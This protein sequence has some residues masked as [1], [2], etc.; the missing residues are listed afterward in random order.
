MR[1]IFITWV[2]ILGVFGVALADDKPTVVAVWEHRVIGR[3]AVP[4]KMTLYSNQKINDP[5]GK[6]VWSRSG[7]TLTLTWPNP[8]A[9]G[10]K[11]VDRCTVSADGKTKKL[12][13]N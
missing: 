8:S 11:W 12:S 13:Q 1:L 9:P 3:D 5:D 10:G 6:N 7:K 4:S 2:T